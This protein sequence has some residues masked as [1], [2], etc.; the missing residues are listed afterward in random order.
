MARLI[1]SVRLSTTFATHDR[2]D[3]VG[4]HGRDLWTWGLAWSGLH[5]RAGAVTMAAL[6]ATTRGR[7]KRANVTVAAKLVEAGLWARTDRGWQILKWADHQSAE[8]DEVGGA[9]REP[10]ISPTSTARVQAPYRPGSAWSFGA[11]GENGGAASSWADGIREVTGLPVSML[12]RQDVKDLIAFAN[13]HAGGLRGQEACDWVRETAAAFARA[14][15]ARFGLTP[16]RCKAWLD[17]G[18]LD[19]RDAQRHGRR[20][21]LVQGGHSGDDG[22]GAEAGASC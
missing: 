21:S 20:I 10:S 14:N 19:C 8:I 11:D 16:R 1:E 13:A 7:G 12:S 17:G 6:L 5:D 15:E 3:A 2:F 4:V 18:R 9:P 22:W